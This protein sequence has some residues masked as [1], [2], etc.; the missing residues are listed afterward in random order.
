MQQKPEEQLLQATEIIA[1][2]IINQAEFDKTIQATIISCTDA[3]KGEYKVRYQGNSFYAYAADLTKTFKKGADVYINVPQNDFGKKKTIISAV[4]NI[5]DTAKIVYPIS[6]YYDESGYDCLIENNITDSIILNSQVKQLSLY[7]ESAQGIGRCRKV[8]LLKEDGNIINDYYLSKV[9]L[10]DFRDGVNHYG[11]FVLRFDIISSID[12]ETVGNSYPRYGI[13]VSFKTEDGS[14]ITEEFNSANMTGN[15]YSYTNKSTQSRYFSYRG[16]LIITK[17]EAFKENFKEGDYAY[18]SNLQLIPCQKLS[19]E[20][21]AQRH[22][23][24]TSLNGNTFSG[25][26]NLNLT[27]E[28]VLREKGEVITLPKDKITYKWFLEQPSITTEDEGY[29]EYAGEG[30]VAAK[31]GEIEGQLAQWKYYKED[32]KQFSRKVKCVLVYTDDENNA[33]ITYSAENI[34]FNNDSKG[35]EFQIEYCLSEDKNNEQNWQEGTSIG[36]SKNMPYLYLR[37][38]DPEGEGWTKK[39][40]EKNAFDDLT[41]LTDPDKDGILYIARSALSDMRIF[42]CSYFK[43]SEYVGY[44]SFAASAVSEDNTPYQLIILNSH[45]VFIYDEYGLAPTEKKTDKKIILKPLSVKIRDNRNNNYIELG[46]EE[47]ATNNVT[48]YVEA[49][50]D[51]RLILIENEL[52]ETPPV[53]KIDEIDYYSFNTPTLSFTLKSSYSTNSNSNN[54]KVK[55]TY[56]G[57]TLW[58]ETSI[59]CYKIGDPGTRSANEYCEIVLKGDD[60]STWEWMPTLTYEYKGGGWHFNLDNLTEGEAWFK[61][62]VWNGSEIIE[63]TDESQ[64]KVTI[65]EWRLLGEKEFSSS[66]R[67]EDFASYQSFSIKDGKFNS[68]ANTDQS[69][70]ENFLSNVLTNS[71]GLFS[72]VQGRVAYKENDVEK[73]LY[74]TSP[75]ATVIKTAALTNYNIQLVDNSGFKYIKYNSAGQQPQF[76]ESRPFQL[77][78]KDSKNNDVS[79]SFTY[80]WKLYSE[81]YDC[82]QRKFV[83]TNLLRQVESSSNSCKVDVKSSVEIS[84]YWCYNAGVGCIIKSGTDIVGYCFFPINIY[85]MTSDNSIVN[86]WDG[87]SLDLGTS[88]DQSYLM[89]NMVGAGTK[90]DSGQF[91]G[92][93][94]GQIASIVED[95]KTTF[96]TG[97]MGYSEGSRSFFVD[98]ED[99]STTLGIEKSGQIKIKPGKDPVIESGN[100]GSTGMRINFGN[101]PS[102]K[103]G[104][105]NFEVDSAGRLVARGANLSSFK[106]QDDLDNDL[107]GTGSSFSLSEEGITLYSK[108][109]DATGLIKLDKNPTLS[110]ARYDTNGDIESGIVYENGNLSITG[111]INAT[112]GSIGGWKITKDY[113][114]AQDGS[115]ILYKDGRIVGSEASKEDSEDD[116]GW[117]DMSN[118]ALNWKALQ[119][120][121]RIYDSKQ[122]GYTTVNNVSTLGTLTT[123][124]NGNFTA[125][126]SG[127]ANLSGSSS[128][129]ISSGGSAATVSGG[130]G[131][132][133]SEKGA[134]VF[135]SGIMKIGD[136]ITNS[137]LTFYNNKEGESSNLYGV[138]RHRYKDAEQKTALEAQKDLSDWEWTIRT[139]KTEKG[140]NGQNIDKITYSVASESEANTFWRDFSALQGEIAVG[141]IDKDINK[142]NSSSKKFVYKKVS[143]PTYTITSVVGQSPQ[144]V[145]LEKDGNNYKITEIYDGQ[146]FNTDK[147]EKLEYHITMDGDQVKSL[148]FPNGY[149]MSLEGFEF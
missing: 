67:L 87:Y 142:L 71:R 52:E 21:M 112:E 60:S 38:T 113:I 93:L 108:Q 74:A 35:N 19:E 42:Y 70:I 109:Q 37:S 121:E 20:E 97:I 75:L 59:E 44:A 61:A 145:K 6:S 91:T 78:I 104:N 89:A 7:D 54:I 82:I 138:K 55:V 77:L 22:L 76:D 4:G 17:V 51:E 25:E 41:I 79:G 147:E 18:I 57:L 123:D 102:I 128:S 24:I 10:N 1:Q 83:E 46:K 92:V 34:L 15:P 96:E 31:N 27:L 45:P 99:G 2:S 16:N 134:R 29:D 43:D 139:V 114:K 144:N 62:R 23:V 129:S 133:V 115:L 101:K 149:V 72:L 36:L 118:K 53:E 58:G 107:N 12:N 122:G 111:T 127:S 110:F 84:S 130:R 120:S 132:S 30:W 13:R 135:E 14:I 94:M 28:A 40:T 39:W 9:L 80:E 105:S 32:V 143:I 126:C 86:D 141:T 106:T 11:S 66:S 85:K 136:N 81:F 95:T 50:R 49:N 103:Y 63:S 5:D 137:F 88:G 8:T 100:Y 73:I 68:K 117:L 65:K 33:A 146:I 124:K 64:E 131:L 140:D 148:T 90:N 69:W 47:P 98:A 119:G 48:W 56:D 116:D 26:D 125:N 3:I